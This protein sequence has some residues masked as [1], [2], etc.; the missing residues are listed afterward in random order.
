MSGAPIPSRPGPG[1]IQPGPGAGSAHQRP[2]APA[3]RAIGTVGSLTFRRATSFLLRLAAAGALLLAASFGPAYASGRS[4]RAS[5]GLTYYIS[6][7]GDDAADGTSPATAWQTLNRATAAQL[8]PGT[9]VLLEGGA[10]FTGP[11]ALTAEDAGDPG[12]PVY[13]GSYGQGLPRSP[14]PAARASSSMTRPGSRSLTS[15]S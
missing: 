3:T 13:V 2:A 14:R 8:P 11:L 15:R 9:Q 4:A 10:Q 7:T 12:N 6:A 5:T 1:R